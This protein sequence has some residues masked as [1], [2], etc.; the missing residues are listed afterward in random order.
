M[1]GASKKS[2]RL[3]RESKPPTTYR[4]WWGSYKKHY[5]LCNSL[6]FRVRR[7]ITF[8][9]KSSPNRSRLACTLLAGLITLR[10]LMNRS[11]ALA[12]PQSQFFDAKGVR[13]HYLIEGTGEPVVLIHGMDSSARINWQAPGTIDALAKHHEA[14]ALDLP[15]FNSPKAF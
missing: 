2:R 5:L 9:S 8:P 6:S 12:A 14:I 10:I 3:S 7:L 1:F 4:Q 15:G 11:A 13:I